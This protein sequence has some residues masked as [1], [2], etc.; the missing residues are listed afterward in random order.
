MISRQF[1]ERNNLFSYL[2]IDGRVILPLYAV[3]FYA[4]YYRLSLREHGIPWNRG[5]ILR[6]NVYNQLIPF[7]FG[8]QALIPL[9]LFLSSTYSRN[10]QSSS[11][12]R[13]LYPN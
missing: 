8:F 4:K 13:T 3:Y 1:R 10:S 12:E 7:A 6:R 11:R 5:Y 2:L 9:Y